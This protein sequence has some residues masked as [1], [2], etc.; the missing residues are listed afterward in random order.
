MS[1]TVRII[2]L[3]IWI[4]IIFVL[5]GYPSLRPPQIQNFPTDKLYHFI[6]FFI[7][8]F[9]ERPLLKPLHFILLGISVALIAEVQQ[10]FV[11][12]RDW[13]ILDIGAGIAGLMAGFLI[14]KK[15]RY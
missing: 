15:R 1:R 6:I 11:P 12:G 8:A 13:E 10:L 4:M 3:I 9:L 2:L 14:F 7:L 5:T